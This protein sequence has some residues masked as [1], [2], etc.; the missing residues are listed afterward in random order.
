MTIKEIKPEKS[1]SHADI[2]SLLRAAL[3]HA[4]EEEYNSVAVVLRGESFQWCECGFVDG[5]DLMALVGMLDELKDKVKDHW[6]DL[7][8]EEN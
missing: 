3:K 2:L 6:R 5:A 8:D 1:K 4:R 7:S